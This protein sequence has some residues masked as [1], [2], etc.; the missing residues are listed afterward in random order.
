MTDLPIAGYI[1]DNART[2]G[3]KK[4]FLEDLRNVA[5]QMPGGSGA[6]LLTIAAGVVT[7]TRSIHAVTT[8]AAASTDDLDAMNPANLPVGSRVTL[9]L[10]DPAR[11]VTIRNNAV[12]TNAIVTVDSLNIELSHVR[13]NVTVELRADLKWYELRR[14]LGPTES[15]SFYGF[16][17]PHPR[18]F[19]VWNDTV[20]G[21]RYVRNGANTLWLFQGL[22]Q[23]GEIK[24]GLLESVL[25]VSSVETTT[26]AA[27]YVNSGL[28]ASIVPVRSAGIRISAQVAARVVEAS[29]SEARSAWR[30]G[31]T[32]PSAANFA[33]QEMEVVATGATQVAVGGAVDLLSRDEGVTPGQT[34]TYQVQQF[35][36]AGDSAV[37]QYVGRRSALLLE[38]F[39]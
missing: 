32:A 5:E 27:N 25:V 7:P 24:V 23:A 9:Y 17:P 22:I 19:D 6:Q 13:Q 28:Q 14:E 8:E 26:T 36:L 37:S 11:V 33:D 16:A 3:D 4:Q 35:V 18:P 34:H 2:E 15:R 1:S 10:S 12:G 38:E 20:N 21:I 39:Q 31:R 29:G 30:I